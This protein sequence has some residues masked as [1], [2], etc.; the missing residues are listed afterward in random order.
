MSET[1]MTLEEAKER[2]TSV[3]HGGGEGVMDIRATAIVLTALDERTKER[4]DLE[5]VMSNHAHA[6]PAKPGRL[7]MPEPNE[8]A[9]QQAIKDVSDA[10][11]YS[12]YTG[13][14]DAVQGIAVIMQALGWWQGRAQSL[15]I[16]LEEPKAGEGEK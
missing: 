14:I 16:Q 8:D 10:T 13:G 3:F 11:A 7:K 1:K 5:V 2:L 4:D 9:I 15:E 6:A 12:R